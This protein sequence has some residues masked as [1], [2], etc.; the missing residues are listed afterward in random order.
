MT[1]AV[2]TAT[3]GPDSL[4]LPLAVPELLYTVASRQ[5]LQVNP[6]PGFHLQTVDSP[7]SSADASFHQPLNHS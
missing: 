4:I 7:Y 1:V 2:V 3:A 6:I 5:A